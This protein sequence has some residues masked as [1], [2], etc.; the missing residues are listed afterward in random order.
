MQEQEEEE[1]VGEVHRNVDRSTLGTILSMASF[2]AGQMVDSGQKQLFMATQ[3]NFKKIIIS[4]FP[5][6]TLAEN[7]IKQ[8]CP[9]G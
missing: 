8:S 5:L 6:I 3:R 4:R 9:P 7:Y 1:D 2:R